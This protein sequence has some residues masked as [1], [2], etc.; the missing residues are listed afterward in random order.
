MFKVLLIS[1]SPAKPAHT[2]ALV[3]EVGSQLQKKGCQITIW[4]LQERPLPFVDPYYHHHPERNPDPVVKEFV[5]LTIEADSFVLGSP[6]Y[7]NSYSGILKNALDILN[8]DNFNGKPVGL[9]A[10]GGGIRSTQPLD[11]LR[12]VVRGLLGLA[13]PMQIAACKSDFTLQGETYMINSSDINNR[14]AAFTNQLINYM[15]K[16]NNKSYIK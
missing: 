14:I 16:L 6:N 10:N 3:K 5:Q 2:T 8:M 11:H 4:D 9:V 15:E 7:H 13:I 12:I 1:G